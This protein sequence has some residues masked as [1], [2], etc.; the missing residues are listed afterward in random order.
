MRPPHGEP[1]VALT[2]RLRRPSISSSARQVAGRKM[3]QEVLSAAP[4][5]SRSIPNRYCLSP[6]PIRS[7]HQNKNR[8]GIRSGSIPSLRVLDLKA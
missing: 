4:G 5:S 3:A 7:P 8:E 2:G 6:A 1:A